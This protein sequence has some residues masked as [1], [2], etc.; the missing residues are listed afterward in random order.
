MNTSGLPTQVMLSE[1][2]FS[3]S[4]Y[5]LLLRVLVSDQMPTLQ[6][7]LPD[8]PIPPATFIFFPAL[9]GVGII[10]ELTSSLLSLLFWSVSAVR[11]Q[12]CPVHKCAPV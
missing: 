10:Y 7:G 8:Y 9:A 1:A 4:S 12:A 3:Q 5:W 2:L 6:G 11:T